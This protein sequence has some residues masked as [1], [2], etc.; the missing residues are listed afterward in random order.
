MKEFYFGLVMCAALTGEKIVGGENVNSTSYLTIS[1]SIPLAL[2]LST[3]Q[4]SSV[5]GT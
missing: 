1:R 5:T 4:S 3:P 2:A